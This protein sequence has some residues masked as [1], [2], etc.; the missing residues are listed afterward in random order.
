M[1]ETT[2]LPYPSQNDVYEIIKINNYITNRNVP[3]DIK[4][5]LFSQA[6]YSANKLRPKEHQD[7]ITSPTSQLYS[8]TISTLNN[9]KHK[10]NHTKNLTLP[11]IL[12]ILN[13]DCSHCNSCVLYPP[14]KY[15]HYGT[16]PNLIYK[17]ILREHKKTIDEWAR[18]TAYYIYKNTKDQDLKQKLEPYTTYKKPKHT[19]DPKTISLNQMKLAAFIVCNTSVECLCCEY[20]TIEKTGSPCIIS[21]ILRPSQAVLSEYGNTTPANI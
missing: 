10:K 14:C 12:K 9:S 17:N 11:I 19:Q 7:D 2:I 6:I 21:T 5:A 1:T 18:Q 8:K 16:L 3:P 13:I 4:D 20:N 15:V